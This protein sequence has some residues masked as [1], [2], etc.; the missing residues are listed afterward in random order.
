VSTNTSY[1][2]IMFGASDRRMFGIYHVPEGESNPSRPAVL[3]CN[4]FGQEAIRA[5]RFQRSLAERL[6]R[7]GHA[8]LRFDYF[9]TGDS[10]GDDL[11]CDL[12]GWTTDLLAG[13]C[14]VRTRA[15]ASSVIWVG[16]RLG[17]TVALRAAQAKTLPEL[18]KLILWDPILDGTRYLGY[19][20][21]RHVASLIRA[22]DLPQQPSP[23]ELASDPTQYRS[24]AI[25]FAISP[26]LRTQVEAIRPEAQLW[27]SDPPN[28]TVITDP[29]SEEGK[30]FERSRP[31][32]PSHINS[33]ELQHG[34]NWTA[35]SA[36]NT[37]LVPANALMAIIQLAAETR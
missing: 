17:A 21:D 6:A 24:E 3:L 7:A 36:A 8:V 22:Y 11:D 14:E 27:S 25:G 5:H 20:R 23:L 9:G 28:I 10:M 26:V 33:L 18:T 35:D 37:P 12:D 32:N 29:A 19:L 31:L 34:T 1:T 13:H 2:P 4:A 30:D 16:M 15:N